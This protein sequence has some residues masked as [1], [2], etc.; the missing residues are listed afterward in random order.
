MT[1]SEKWA[2]YLLKKDVKRLMIELKKKWIS[3]GRLSGS[4]ILNQVSDIEKRDIEGIT[5]NHYQND[6]VVISAKDFERNFCY[7]K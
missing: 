6:K 5:G 3:Y 4:I 2:E 7:F 1:G